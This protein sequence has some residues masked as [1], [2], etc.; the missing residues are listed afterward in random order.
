MGINGYLIMFMRQNDGKL[1]KRR[2]EK[3]FTA[4]TDDE[5]THI[6]EIYR[7]SFAEESV[8]DSQTQ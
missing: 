5:V 8:L 6:E 1:A 4:L 7:E 2:R 3:E